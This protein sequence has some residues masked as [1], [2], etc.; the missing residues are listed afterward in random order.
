MPPARVASLPPRGPAPPAAAA[1]A[2]LGPVGVTGAGDWVGFVPR[3]GVAG[4]SCW[5]SFADCGGALRARFCFV[6]CVGGVVWVGSSS[7]WAGGGWPWKVSCKC[8]VVGSTWSCVCGGSVVL[9]PVAFDGGA[10]WGRCCLAFA[11]GALLGLFSLA[12]G[13]VLWGSCCWRPGGGGGGDGVLLSLAVAGSL[14]LLLGA[15]PFSLADTGGG[16]ALLGSCCLSAGGAFVGVG[17]LL[18]L[19]IGGCSSVLLLGAFSFSLANTGGGGG[20]LLGSC[21]FCL[22]GGVA[23]GVGV[24]VLTF[25]PA[26]GCL[27][28]LMLGA[29]SFSFA[30]TSGGLLFGA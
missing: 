10:L 4:G 29:F 25:G 12:E 21:G 11:G 13:G 30:D 8:V 20:V 2:L 7:L 9:V 14:E 6:V 19:A 18:F 24:G 1:A 16:G 15:F 28:E 23:G 3:V 5:A 22:G 27:S 17:V 26:G